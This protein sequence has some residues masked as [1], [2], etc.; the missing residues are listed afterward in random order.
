M[1]AKPVGSY[2]DRKDNFSHRFTYTIFT[3]KFKYQ[4]IDFLIIKY[5]NGA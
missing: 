5:N 2:I 1:T 4:L 3:E